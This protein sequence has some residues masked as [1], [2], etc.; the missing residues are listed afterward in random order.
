MF[1]GLKYVT[2]KTLELDIASKHDIFEWNLENNLNKLENKQW[3][4]DI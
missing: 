4:N 2:G 1:T 3:Y